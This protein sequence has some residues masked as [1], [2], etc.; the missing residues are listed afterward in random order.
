MNWIIVYLH[1]NLKGVFIFLFFCGEFYKCQFSTY[2]LIP[3]VC[4]SVET[5][6][7]CYKRYQYRNYL[8]KMEIYRKFLW[9]NRGAEVFW[10]MNWASC[11]WVYTLSRSSNFILKICA[12]YC[13]VNFAWIKKKFKEASNWIFSDL[14]QSIYIYSLHNFKRNG[15]SF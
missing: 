12:F 2:S 11:T 9:R 5:N 1:I 8:W 3:F 4:R 15:E 14:L 13:F 7:I 6:R 10:A